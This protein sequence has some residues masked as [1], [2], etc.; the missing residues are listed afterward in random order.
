MK[1][2]YFKKILQENLENNCISWKTEFFL[3]ACKNVSVEGI[4]SDENILSNPRHDIDYLCSK[5]AQKFNL[6]ANF[7]GYNFFDRKQNLIICI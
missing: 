3:E 7:N 6:H 5:N 2:K 1:L 4:F